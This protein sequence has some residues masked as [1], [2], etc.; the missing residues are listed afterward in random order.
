[1]SD[2]QGVVGHLEHA[3]ELAIKAEHDLQQAGAH[4]LIAGGMTVQG[5]G[6]HVTGSALDAIGATGPAGATHSLGDSLYHAAHQQLEEAGHAA[7]AASDALFGSS[8]PPPPP[9]SQ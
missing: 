3:V 9:P 4:L 1:M 7:Q 5:A 8:A 2:Q 6:S